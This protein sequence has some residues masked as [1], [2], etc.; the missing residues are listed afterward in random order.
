MDLVEVAQCNT[1][2]ELR[3][4]PLLFNTTLFLCFLTH[5]FPLWAA[6]LSVLENNANS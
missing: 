3:R 4:S 2:F 1:H 6:A 5:E